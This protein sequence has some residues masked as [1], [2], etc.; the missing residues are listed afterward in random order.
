ME[1]GETAAQRQPGACLHA[2]GGGTWNP[3]L[4]G[5]SE[6]NLWALMDYSSRT[7]YLCMQLLKKK[8]KK[9]LFEEKLLRRRL[10]ENPDQGRGE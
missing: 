7:G 10:R 6:N 3:G 5:L 9:N 1:D 4:S 8:K 2:I